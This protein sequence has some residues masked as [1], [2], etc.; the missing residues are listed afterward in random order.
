MEYNKLVRDKIPHIIKKDHR[1]CE[2]EILS[3][4]EFKKALKDKLIEE[5]TELREADSK[6]EIIEELADIYEVLETILMQ[7]I[8]DKRIIDKKRIHKNMN[9]GAFEDKILLKRVK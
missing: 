9:K 8:I 6:D 7:E 3:D 1:E 4:T 5:A 2:T